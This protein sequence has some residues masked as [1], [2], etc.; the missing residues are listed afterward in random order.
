M[1]TNIKQLKKRIQVTS[2]K[3]LEIKQAVSG[4]DACSHPF[5]QSLKVQSQ[6]LI[7]QLEIELQTLSKDLSNKIKH[8]Y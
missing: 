8:L 2:N 4:S 5:S 6:Y 3:I 1:K 7:V